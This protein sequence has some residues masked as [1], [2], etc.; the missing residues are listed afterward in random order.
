M[1]G[2]MTIDELRRSLAEP[3]SIADREFDI[4][5]NI[6]LI[7]GDPAQ[8]SEAREL[9]LRALE[10]RMAF[11]TTRPIVESLTRTVGLFPYTDVEALDLR[12]RIAY[13]FNRPLN[14]APDFVFHREQTEVYHRLLAGESVIL[15]AP[16]S[17]GKSRII[18]AVI[19]SGKFANIVVV[20]P[21][22]A[23][24]DETRRRLAQFSEDFKIVTHLSQRPAKK[25]IF[26]LTAERAVAYAHFPKIEFFV[27]DEFYKLDD[28]GDSPGADPSRAVALNIAFRKLWRMRGQFYLLGPNVERIPVEVREKLQC[29]LHFTDFAT[30]IAEPHRV[31]RRGKEMDRLVELCKRLDEPTLIFCRS[32]ARANT[33]AARLVDE[34][35]GQTAVHLGPA[36]Q[37]AARHYHPDWIWGRAIVNGIG[38]HHGR[39]P[40]ALAQYTVRMFNDLSLRFLICTSTLIEGVNTK[41]KNVVV[42]DDKIAKQQIDFFTFNNIKGRSGRMFEHFIGRVF[43]FAEP[44]DEQLPFVDF[45][46]FTQDRRVPDSLLVQ[47]ADEDLEVDA[48]ARAKKWSEQEVL[49][50]NVLRENATIDPDAQLSLAREIRGDARH[51][52]Q[53][54]SWN[55]IPSVDQLRYVCELIWSYFFAETRFKSGVFSGRQLAFKVWQLRRVKDSSVRV[56]QELEPGQFAARSPD[57]AVE[58]VLQFER[59][60]AGFEFP[61]Y[62]MAVSRIQEYVLQTQGLSSGD[63]RYFASQV[64]CLF[65]NPVV[66]ALDE[67]GIPL[68]VAE[69]IESLLGSTD[70]L[71]VALHNLKRADLTTLKLDRFELELLIDAARAL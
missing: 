19:A 41:A 14:M 22:L 23:L 61:R 52:E 68:Q 44:P 9:V 7:V 67:Y 54:L 1:A 5:K 25:N 13:E 70:D 34:E 35:L 3:A 4:V 6:G 17:F 11:R 2:E 64:E 47:I 65:R 16:T 58:R 63:Y 28:L 69:R 46:L 60:W 57:D 53:L 26:V 71:D 20:V 62:L 43:L 56:R 51:V 24:I 31:P 55:R 66:A 42:F 37:W 49:D 32:P 50:V 40:R 12:D 30:V 45:P 38:V 27:I 8:E 48:K 36:A 21:T 18:D 39:L 10:H 15:S 29:H 33:I 59:V